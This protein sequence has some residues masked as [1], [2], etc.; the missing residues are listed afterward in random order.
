MAAIEFT[1]GL[2]GLLLVVG[3]VVLILGLILSWVDRGERRR[4]GPSDEGVPLPQNG[5]RLVRA[6]FF[7]LLFGFVLTGAAQLGDS[8]RN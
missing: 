1:G 8:L 3:A 4:A 2:G 6:A 5:R 7:V